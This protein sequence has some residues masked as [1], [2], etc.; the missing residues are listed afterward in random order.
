MALLAP[1]ERKMS[2]TVSM[3]MAEIE[4][5]KRLAY[6]RQLTVSQL[7]LNLIAEEKAKEKAA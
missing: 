5:T 4:Q 3:K 7:I 6:E 2:F 1:E